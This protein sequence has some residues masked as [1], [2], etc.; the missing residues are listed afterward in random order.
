LKG[1]PE[2]AVL[3]TSPGLAYLQ[4]TGSALASPIA[5]HTPI[6]PTHSTETKG[7]AEDVDRISVASVSSAGVAGVGA[8]AKTTA[9]RPRSRPSSIVVPEQ[10]RAFLLIRKTELI[11]RQDR[12][13][14]KRGVRPIITSRG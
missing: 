5:P 2:R 1:F 12:E 8:G 14:G 7:D 3:P 13:T 10:V 4:E 6:S 11:C 9:P